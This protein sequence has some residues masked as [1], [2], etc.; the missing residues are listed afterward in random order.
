MTVKGSEMRNADLTNVETCTQSGWRGKAAPRT[1]FALALTTLV[2]MTGS[3]VMGGP[4]QYTC[5][6]EVLDIVVTHDPDCVLPNCTGS[7]YFVFALGQCSGSC[8][9]ANWCLADHNGENLAGFTFPCTKPLDPN[10]TEC[11]LDLTRGTRITTNGTC[12][13]GI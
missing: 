9:S 5:S 4:Y 12:F 6:R 13:C 10:A 7:Y 3:E 1:A 11:T 8:P 2:G